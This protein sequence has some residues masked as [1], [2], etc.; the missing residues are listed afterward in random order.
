M[1]LRIKIILLLLFITCCLSCNAQKISDEKLFEVFNKYRETKSL[2][3][4]LHGGRWGGDSPEVEKY[5][6]KDFYSLANNFESVIYVLNDD[7]E[8]EDIR[9]DNDKNFELEYGKNNTYDLNEKEII[10]GKIIDNKVEYFTPEERWKCN[11]GCL[12]VLDKGIPLVYM[13]GMFDAYYVLEKHVPVLLE[14][15]KRTGEKY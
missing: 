13:D 12:F 1:K 7:F 10:I 8:F 6:H 3:Y 2:E 15:L 5:M 14:R 9:I 11:G 4:A